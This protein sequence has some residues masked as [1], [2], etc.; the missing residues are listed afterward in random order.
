[1]TTARRLAADSTDCGPALLRAVSTAN[2]RASIWDSASKKIMVDTVAARVNAG[3][4]S[5]LQAVL[6]T[7][8]MPSC[9]QTSFP[10]LKVWNGS[11]GPSWSMLA[12]Q[13][14]QGIMSWYWI[15]LQGVPAVPSKADEATGGLGLLIVLKQTSLTPTESVWSLDIGAASAGKW[16]SP[17]TVYMSPSQVTLLADGVAFNSPG[18]SGSIRVQTAA[19]SVDITMGATGA[20]IKKATATSRRGPTYEQAGGNIKNAGIVQNGYWS[21][22]DGTLS[23]LSY[24]PAAS[25]PEIT[26]TTGTAWLDYQQIGIAPLKGLQPIMLAAVGGVRNVRTPTGPAWLFVVIQTPT[27]QLSAYI[28]AGSELDVFKTGEKTS[29]LSVANVWVPGQPAEYN[30]PAMFQ[31]L[32]TYA[33]TNVPSTVQLVLLASGTQSGAT[34]ELHST[35]LPSGAP[36]FLKSASGSCYESPSLVSRNGILLDDSRAVIEWVEPGLYPTTTDALV[37]SGLSAR[38]LDARKPSAS[39]IAT[40]AIVSALILA[41]FLALVVGIP[42]ASARHKQQRV[43]RTQIG[44]FRDSRVLRPTP[45]PS[46]FSQLSVNSYM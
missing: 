25:E 10:P 46:D 24:T 11:P 17:E 12:P 18:A 41:A 45:D 9:F 6:A 33:S 21:I 3:A 40:I 44:T 30:V 26:F 16:D 27:L 34:F 5:P 32:G 29:V 39:A 19:I 28:L 37:G 31:L 4:V 13:P 20:V 1:M 14:A 23:N 43:H 2:A 7:A 38:I 15:L 22:V 42:V 8:L 35:V 36:P